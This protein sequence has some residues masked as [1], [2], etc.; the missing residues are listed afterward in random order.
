M[1]LALRILAALLILLVAAGWLASSWVAGKVRETFERE[2]GR[3]LRTRVELASVSI[4]PVSGT[5]SL[6]GLDIGNPRGYQ[7]P[8]FFKIQEARIDLDPRSLAGDGPLLIQTILLDG[9]EITYEK[10]GLWDSNIAA[11]LRGLESRK[12]APAPTSPTTG[13]TSPGRGVQIDE[14]IIRNAR[15]N[16]SSALMLGHSLPLP[17]DEIRLTSLGTGGN[18]MSG[19]DV[20]RT[21]MTA[22]EN[23]MRKALEAGGRAEAKSQTSRTTPE[24]LS[25]PAA[26]FVHR[27]TF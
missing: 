21:F 8:S 6:Q 15:V 10:R 20:L 14:L 9:P 17:L 4:N 23:G 7:T 12:D 2:G 3:V 27:A 19:E 5:A 26:L 1:K 11:L 13:G 18:S 24:S 25:T 22:L 16:L